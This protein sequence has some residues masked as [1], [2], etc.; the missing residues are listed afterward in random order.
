MNLNKEQKISY[1]KTQLSGF[2]LCPYRERNSGHILSLSRCYCLEILA[3]CGEKLKKIG[4]KWPFLC[5]RKTVILSF[6]LFNWKKFHTWNMSKLK[7][8]ISKDTL[9]FH[10]L[11]F[12]FCG[13]SRFLQDIS[14]RPNQEGGKTW[15]LWVNHPI[16]ARLA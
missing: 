4:P 6:V 11:C 5:P 12:D 14:S 15:D 8:L 16:T 2:S 7:L 13:K 3:F 9:G 1:Q 10:V